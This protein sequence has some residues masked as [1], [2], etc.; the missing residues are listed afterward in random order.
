MEYG[1]PRQS[2]GKESICQGRRQERLRFDP[3][4]RKILWRKEMTI[5]SSIL[6]GKLHGQ[7]SLV[8]YSL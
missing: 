3:S 4:V 1:L 6:A 5:S 7:R 8:D 2:S